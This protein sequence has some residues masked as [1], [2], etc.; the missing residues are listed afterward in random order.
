MV[1]P[2]SFQGRRLQTKTSQILQT[3][4]IDYLKWDLIEMGFETI[5]ESLWNCHSK[6]GLELLA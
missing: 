6:G 3:R 2:K 4:M 5:L 1:T